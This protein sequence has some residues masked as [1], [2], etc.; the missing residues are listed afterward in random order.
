VFAGLAATFIPMAALAQDASGAGASAKPDSSAPTGK[1]ERAPASS[2]DGPS[3]D[4][5]ESKPGDAASN[6]S[7]EE[8]N[9]PGENSEAASDDPDPSENDKE[10]RLK[11]LEAKLEAQTRR[12]E[13]LEAEL[14]RQADESGTKPKIV[15]QEEKKKDKEEAT[16]IESTLRDNPLEI[17]ED[18]DFPKSVPLFGSKFRFGIGGYVKLDAIVDA[19]NNTNRYAFSSGGISMSGT[20][21][22]EQG[23]YFSMHPFESRLNVDVR[24]TEK[25]APPNQAFIEFDFFT[26]APDRLGA[27]RLRHAYFRWGDFLAGQTTALL[28]DPRILPFIIDFAFADSVNAIRIPQIRYQTKLKDWLVLRAGLE[29]PERGGIDNPSELSGAASSLLPRV[30]VGFSFEAPRY[31]VSFGVSLNEIR[32]DAGAQGS[33]SALAWAMVVN[34]RIF[35]DKEKKSFLGLHGMLGD[36]TAE[37]VG[38]FVG[39]NANALLLSNQTLLAIPAYHLLVGYGHRWHELFSTNLAFALDVLER[40]QVSDEAALSE[41]AMAATWN[42]HGNV[43]LHIHTAFQIGLEYMFAERTNENGDRGQDQ[44]VQSMAMYRF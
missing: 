3:P 34:S 39:Q 1:P 8:A 12:I 33:S 28:S 4:K 14:V 35:L 18:K 15:Q 42:F 30:A 32:W 21:D 7:D 27:P 10:A 38:A 22:A 29:M 44:R 2:Q 31:S 23:A 40:D 5:D 16:S 36:G 6:G 11:E 17:A 43:L 26:T 25:D 24:Y 20:P 13:G 41:A 9:S 19:G 37:T